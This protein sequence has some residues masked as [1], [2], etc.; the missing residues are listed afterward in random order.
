MARFVLGMPLILLLVSLAP[1]QNPPQSDPQAVSFA[2][3]SI[4]ALTGG[5]TV[6]DVTMTGSLT[7]SGRTDILPFSNQVEGQYDS[8]NLLS[9]SV[10]FVIS[11]DSRGWSRLSQDSL[12]DCRPNSA[13]LECFSP[14]TK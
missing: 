9:N 4:V 12:G 3:Q 14:F 7:W 2:S 13:E 5:T 8:I 6:S 1:A 11:I 10:L